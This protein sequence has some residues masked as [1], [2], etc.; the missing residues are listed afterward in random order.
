MGEGVGVLV[1]KN[2]EHAMK[3]G[4]P[5]VVMYLGGAVD[6]DAHHMADL[7][8][9]ELGVSS[10][11]KSILEGADVTHPIP[12]EEEVLNVNSSSHGE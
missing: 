1:M 12:I 8:F 9:D 10:C 7:R 5:A 11:I 2:L 4:A 3:R 6:Y